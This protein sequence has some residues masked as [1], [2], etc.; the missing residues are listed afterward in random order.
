MNREG[1][2]SSREMAGL[3]VG[4]NPGHAASVI[5]TSILQSYR[6]D[7]PLAR[8]GLDVRTGNRTVGSNPTLS[9]SFVL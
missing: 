1:N 6:R 9:T 3:S 4:S 2:P 5:C 7:T 8:S